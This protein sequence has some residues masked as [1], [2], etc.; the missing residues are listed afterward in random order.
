M[1]TLQVLLIA[2][3]G[4]LLASSIPLEHHGKRRLIKVN[5]F[6]PAKWLEEKEIWDLIEKDIKFMDITEMKNFPER[7]PEISQNKGT[8]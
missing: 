1:K 4:V 7:K 5:E 3:F 8:H 2:S 6:E